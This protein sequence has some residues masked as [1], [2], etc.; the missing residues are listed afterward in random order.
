MYAPVLRKHDTGE[1]TA[2]LTAFHLQ[3]WY[4]ISCSCQMNSSVLDSQAPISQS[5]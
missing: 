5:R 4:E 3:G 2:C 1:G